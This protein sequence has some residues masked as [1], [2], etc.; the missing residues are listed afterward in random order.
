MFAMHVHACTWLQHLL[1]S[2]FVVRFLKLRWIG[3]KVRR[4][5][6]AGAALKPDSFGSVSAADVHIGQGQNTKQH[7]RFL[8]LYIK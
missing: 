4:Q 3:Q 7:D 6:L 8:D 1:S 5:G 2:V